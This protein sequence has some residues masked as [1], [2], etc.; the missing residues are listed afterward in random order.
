MYCQTALGLLMPTLQKYRRHV[1]QVHAADLNDGH[2]A[3]YLPFA[4]N[5]TY[6]NANNAWE[7]HKVALVAR[8]RAAGFALLDTQFLVGDHMRQFGAIE[9]PRL[10]YLRRLHAATRLPVRF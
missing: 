9:I 1:K 5:G 6:P 2:G 8:L 3:G 10:A 7:R 4:R